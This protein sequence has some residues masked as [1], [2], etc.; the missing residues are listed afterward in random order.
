MTVPDSALTS[1]KGDHLDRHH[2]P[3]FVSMQPH[4][5]GYV[6]VLHHPFTGAE[7][8]PREPETYRDPALTD[9]DREII[10]REYEA[11]SAV[12]EKARGSRELGLLAA[13]ALPL[14]QG[15][16]RAAKSAEAAYAAL[17]DD[18]TLDSTGWHAR[19]LR[20]VEA[21]AAMLAAARAFD[22]AGSE[23]ATAYDKHSR[24]LDYGDE[25]ALAEILA[26]SGIDADGWEIGFPHDYEG[27][28]V[29]STAGAGPL[30]R[31]AEQRIAQHKENLRQVAELTGDR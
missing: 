21:H 31:I 17:T 6:Q 26:D 8:A 30:A 25:R 5:E 10:R 1:A 27:S 16:T 15:W 12:W 20:L 24:A 28:S 13:K 11:L 18:S 2:H 14:W 19:T 29:Y 23:I 7:S 22:V 9:V 4:G 3:H